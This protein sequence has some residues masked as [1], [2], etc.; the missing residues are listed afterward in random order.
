MNIAS[1]FVEIKL[2]FYLLYQSVLEK[3][4][5]GN[6]HEQISTVQPLN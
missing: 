3:P 6:Q 1:S 4:E 2:Y 5:N